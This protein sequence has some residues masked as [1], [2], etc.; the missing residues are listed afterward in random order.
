MKGNGLYTLTSIYQNG[1]QNKSNIYKN[2]Y[3]IK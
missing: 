2:K 1:M 3:K